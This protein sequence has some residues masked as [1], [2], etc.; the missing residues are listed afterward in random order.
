MKCAESHISKLM[1][2][3]TI[4]ERL[5]AMPSGARPPDHALTRLAD[6]T[7]VAIH[8]DLLK[9]VDKNPELTMHG[10]PLAVKQALW[11]WEKVCASQ[12]VDCLPLRP[13]H[14]PK[15][16]HHML[17]QCRMKRVEQ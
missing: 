10:H 16:K 9:A 17:L 8:E 3:Q 2:S 12:A 7:H 13:S 1:D 15:G 5:E 14:A 6:F 11:M 4:S